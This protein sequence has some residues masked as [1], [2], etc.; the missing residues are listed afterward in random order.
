M[1]KKNLE[2]NGFK[3]T[4]K[5]AALV[6][7]EVKEVIL[8]IGNND[9]SIFSDNEMERNLTY[10][11]LQKHNSGNPQIGIQN[12]AWYFR[13]NLFINFTDVSPFFRSVKC[14]N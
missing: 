11:R 8:F 14:V 10:L 4:V 13:K 12:G 2:L 6:H 3:A 9:H 1:I 5:Q 7:N